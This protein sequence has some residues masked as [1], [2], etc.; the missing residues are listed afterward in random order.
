MGDHGGQNQ[1]REEVVEG[2]YYVYI[3]GG[4]CSGREQGRKV[5]DAEGKGS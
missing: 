2:E 5:E 1:G 4:R 3:Q